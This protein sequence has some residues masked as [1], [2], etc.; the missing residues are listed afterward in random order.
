MSDPRVRRAA[1]RYPD[2]HDGVRTWHCFSAGR[3][4]DPDNLSHGPVIAVDEHLLDPGAGFDWHD[5]RDVV[6]WSWVLDG[7][8]RHQRTEADR[9]IRPGELFEQYAEE[10]VRHRETNGGDGP[11]RFVQSTA[12]AGAGAR[13]R[14][15]HGAFS[16]SGPAHLFVAGGQFQLGA[17]D[18]DAGDSARLTGHASVEGVGQAIVVEWPAVISS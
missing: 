15:E 16:T 3:H 2:V 14:I 13:A 5:H 17:V 9:L 6:I 8:L 7:T 11:L 12:L 18:L 1:D 4:Y 10:P